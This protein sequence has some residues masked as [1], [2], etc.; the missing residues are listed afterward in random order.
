LPIAS[1]MALFSSRLAI[2]TSC[3]PD[4]LQAFFAMNQLAWLHF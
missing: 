2:D 3:W 1:R 4:D